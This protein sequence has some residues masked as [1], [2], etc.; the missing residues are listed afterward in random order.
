MVLNTIIKEPHARR[1]KI[2]IDK[3]LALTHDRPPP[4]YLLIY[5]EFVENNLQLKFIGQWNFKAIAE[6][7]ADPQLL[8]KVPKPN[9]KEYVQFLWDLIGGPFRYSGVL[10]QLNR[11]GDIVLFENQMTIDIKNYTC[12]IN[13]PTYGRGTPYS[14]FYLEGDKIVEKVFENPN[15]S[16]SVVLLEDPSQHSCILLDRNLANSLLMRLFFFKGKGLRYFKPFI[17][18]S[19]LTQRTQIQTYEI[20]WDQFEKDF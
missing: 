3:I 18:A 7:N 2:Q 1:K 14:L 20:D 10:P 8:Q 12:Q 19:D 13:S 6:I 16:Y 15:L 4:S 17:E 5:K 9:S 11:A